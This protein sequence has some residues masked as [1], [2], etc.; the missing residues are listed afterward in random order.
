M[1][2]TK[3]LAV[4]ISGRGSNLQAIINAIVNKTLQRC[5]VAIVISDKE[6]ALGLKCA[7]EA[8]IETTFLDPTKY[9]SRE[10]F[11]LAVHAI[12]IHYQIDFVLL[13]GYMRLL[14]AEFV[15]KWKEKVINIHPSLL[16]A[17]PGLH[18][19]RQALEYGVKYSGCTT[20]FIDEGLDT[21]PIIMQTAVPIDELDTEETLSERILKEEHKIY[22]LTIQL[23][24]DDRIRIEGRKTLLKP[25]IVNE[26]I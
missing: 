2:E 14:S 18:A 13:A 24:V 6:D 16:P 26:K 12:L 9:T 20:H 15:R 3:N 5:K 17:F 23:L 7:K 22:P 21:G 4:F 11:D 19:Q 1:V 25:Q 8:G 10:Q